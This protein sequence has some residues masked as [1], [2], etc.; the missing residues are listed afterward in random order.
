MGRNADIKRHPLHPEG[1]AID[2]FARGARSPVVAELLAT[3]WITR[4]SA[5]SGAEPDAPEA[6]DGAGKR[7]VRDVKVQWDPELQQ[8]E[9]FEVAGK[10]RYVVEALIGHWIE[11]RSWWDPDLHVSRRCF[12]VLARGGVWDL[13]YDLISRSWSLVGIG[14]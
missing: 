9:W 14:D 3:P 10:G 5:L 2:L 1:Q 4:A 7:T 8:P 13:A 11:D 12:R 6:G